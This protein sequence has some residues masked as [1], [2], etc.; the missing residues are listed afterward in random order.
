MILMWIRAQS[1]AAQLRRLYL[2]YKQLA[3]ST[4]GIVSYGCRQAA[5]KLSL[6]IQ[7]LEEVDRAQTMATVKGDGEE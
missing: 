2:H 4:T 5:E 3:K 7:Y 1:D 6:A